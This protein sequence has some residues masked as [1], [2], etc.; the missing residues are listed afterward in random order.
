MNI[1]LSD[2][3]QHRI[4]WILD[5]PPR[6]QMDKEVV[7]AAIKRAHVKTAALLGEFFIER[8]VP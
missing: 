5:I 6:V 3:D 7:L 2:E 8:L 1:E 4:K